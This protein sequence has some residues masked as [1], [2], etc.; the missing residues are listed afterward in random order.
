MFTP[1][2]CTAAHHTPGPSAIE[3]ADGFPLARSA[4]DPPNLVPSWPKAMPGAARW[5]GT[6][7]RRTLFS[8]HSG[9]L[10]SQAGSAPTKLLRRCASR[11]PRMVVRGGC[12]I[13]GVCHL[14]PFA[15]VPSR[16]LARACTAAAIGP[17]DVRRSS[18]A[19]RRLMPRCTR[20]RDDGGVWWP[21]LV[22]AAIAAA[23]GCAST[24]P[25]P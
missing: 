12:P 6:G 16:R 17:V 22:P 23:S 18:R 14:P 5:R 13:G 24:P 21:D 9:G 4:G 15:W 20:K 2:P 11:A 25:P 3:I 8:P 10:T 7:W 19:R 1:L